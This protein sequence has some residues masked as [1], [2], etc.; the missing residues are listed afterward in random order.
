MLSASP[1]VQTL[2]YEMESI[3]EDDKVTTQDRAERFGNAIENNR[4]LELKEKREALAAMYIAQGKMADPNARYNLGEEPQ[5]QAECMDMCPE[6][7]R[8]ER[9][10]QNGLLKFEL[11]DSFDLD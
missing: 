5:F 6:Y 11:V 7:E 3:Q 4:F 8:H 9:E 1:T 10:Y 2:E